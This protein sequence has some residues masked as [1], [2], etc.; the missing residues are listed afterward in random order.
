MA[1][2]RVPRYVATSEISVESVDRLVPDKTRAENSEAA[3]LNPYS[4]SSACR[5]EPVEIG[6]DVESTLVL[7]CFESEP[8]LDWQ[9][10]NSNTRESRAM[11]FMG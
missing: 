8:D 5:F 9:P 1:G 11:D 6:C 10:S 2:R 4:A 7:S 3:R